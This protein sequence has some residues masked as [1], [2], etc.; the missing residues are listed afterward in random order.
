MKRSEVMVFAMSNEFAVVVDSASSS[1]A[2][3]AAAVLSKYKKKLKLL[4][5]S[6]PGGRS[7]KTRS[8]V[9]SVAIIAVPKILN[10]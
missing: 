6:P 9:V 3:A 7:C 4:P 10:A 8:A 5:K 2:A 1:S